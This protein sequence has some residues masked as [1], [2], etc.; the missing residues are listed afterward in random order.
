[1]K[2][3]ELL[4]K[5]D[6]VFGKYG[7]KKRFIVSHPKFNEQ[8]RVAAPSDTAAIVA[9]ATAFG[10]KTWTEYDFYSNCSAVP[11]YTQIKTVRRKG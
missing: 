5:I 10:A 11:D 4:D 8:V 9:E 2:D 6:A 7:G 3:N 1:M